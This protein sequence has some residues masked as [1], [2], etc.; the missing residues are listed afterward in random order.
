[1]SEKSLSVDTSSYDSLPMSVFICEPQSADG[2]QDFQIVYANRAFADYWRRI[3]K[4]DDFI[5][6]Y[7][8]KS[9][10][11]DES[12]LSTIERFR[13][14][15]PVSFSTYLPQPNLYLHFEPMTNLPEPYLGFFIM[16]ISDYETKEAKLHFLRNVRQMQ[17]TALLVQIFDDGSLKPL[18]VSDEYAMLM[19]CSVDELM[20]ELTKNGILKSTHPEDRHLVR[21]MLKRR[22]SDDGTHDLTIRKITGKGNTVWCHVHYAFIDDFDEHYIYCTAFNVTV[23]K[24]YEDRLR[25]V[26]MSLGNSF[27]QLDEKPLGIFR[28]N[29]T[30]DTIEDIKGF[31]LFDTDSVNR[32]YSELLRLRSLNY[33][34]ESERERLLA[35]LDNQNLID[36]YLAGRVSVKAMVYSRRKS[37]LYCFIT[38]EANMTRH[39][40]S[41]EMIAFIT[42]KECNN[43]KVSAMMTE[44]ILV[45]QFD[46]VSYIANGKYGV[47]IGD[48]AR[49]GKGS[50]FPASRTG[51]YVHYIE[52]QVKPV[53]YGTDEYKQAVSEALAPEAIERELAVQEP[54]V[55]NIAIEIDGEVYHKR[56]DFYTA[57]PGARFYILL[58]SDTTA[59]QKEQMIRNEQL[60]IALDEAKQAS[61][62]KTAFL[63]SMSHEIRTPMNAIIGLDNIA[64]KD[65]GLTPQTKEHL[66]KIGMSAN[67]LLGLI[68]DILDMSRIESGRMTLKHEEFSFS[69]FLDQINTIVDSQCRDKN[70]HYDCV[71]HGKID[72]RYIGD[73]MKLKQVLINI[74]GNAVKFTPSPGTVSLSVERTAQFEKQTTLKFV[75][76]DTGIGMDKSYLPKIFDAFSQEDSTATNKYGGSGLG[77]AITK[78]IVQL[79]NGNI[80]VDSEKGKGT[81]FTVTVTL[82][83]SENSNLK[84]ED[85]NLNPHELKVLVIDDDEV[86]CQHAHIILEEIG[87]V[88][89][90]CM[91]GKE[92]VRLIQTKYARQESYNLILV[93]W[94]MPEED[95]VEVTR[96]IREIIG[97]E[98]AV[99]IL[100]AYNWSEIEDRA[101][102]AGVDSFMSKPLFASGVL[103]EFKQALH[104]KHLSAVG[105]APRADL[106]GRRVLLAEDMPIN[107][108]IMKELL[109]MEGMEVDHA[110]NGQIAVDKLRESEVGFYSAVLMDVRMPVMDGLTATS[111]IR[112]LAHADAK[113]IPIIAMTA[114]AF[115]EDVQRSLQ[116]GMTA[117]LSKPVE[118]EKLYDSLATLIGAREAKNS[119][120]QSKEQGKGINYEYGK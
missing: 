115:D 55:V 87:I 49:I 46:M 108:E 92:A 1:M 52:S 29:L 116:A 5:G 47:V 79:M 72:E 81:T 56:F 15:E 71:V 40:M 113:D 50:I 33:P 118:P 28:V 4:D 110:E 51:G 58:K 31:D 82:S 25:G 94:K 20:S 54:Y 22:V 59:I 62:A 23:L 17:N 57:E 35:L 84:M 96:Q 120:N 3:Y 97:R 6:A 26:Y 60:K 18:F 70:L 16:N 83:N 11:L 75:I 119:G 39:P 85:F 103:N 100:T 88:S 38:M 63:S 107:A 112:A 19:E 30:R 10:L 77:L 90:T 66:E 111:T 73:D 21:N 13:Y 53:L 36:N 24:T 34:I 45:Q 95:G 78:N 98:A 67:H 9:S 106:H 101:K 117:H 65:P 12:S 69:A 104:K 80:A 44:K 102:S 27:Y 114:N 105:E 91:S 43:E 2:A 14:E 7:L 48:A 8:R 86:A 32:P 109:K 64:L 76:A 99:V 93:D 61:V 74:L 89:D 42:E 41:G 68:N 37:G